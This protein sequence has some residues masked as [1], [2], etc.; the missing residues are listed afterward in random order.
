MFKELGLHFNKHWVANLYR[1]LSV[2][3]CDVRVYAERNGTV[4]LH[5]RV[6]T[7]KDTLWARLVTSK[8]QNPHDFKHV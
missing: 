7:Y 2:I 4:R 1:K 3:K 6:I 8:K 5:V